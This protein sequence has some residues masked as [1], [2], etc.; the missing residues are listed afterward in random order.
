MYLLTISLNIQRCKL[1]S[2]CER[3]DTVGT[4]D[5]W[6]CDNNYNCMCGCLQA[7]E[8]DYF[9]VHIRVFGDWTEELVRQMGVGSKDF[10]QAWQLPK[11]VQLR[12]YR[13]VQSNLSIML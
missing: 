10:T 7:P 4:N 6:L 5:V 1:Y 2:N 11:Y 8:E 12:L 9:S 3:I 13:P